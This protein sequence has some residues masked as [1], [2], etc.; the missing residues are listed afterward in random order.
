M[1]VDNFDFEVVSVTEEEEDCNCSVFKTL[2]YTLRITYKKTKI[3]LLVD[4]QRFKG[5]EPLSNAEIVKYIHKIA[6]DYLNGEW[7]LKTDYDGVKWY[8]TQKLSDHRD[9]SLNK[10]RCWGNLTRTLQT[11]MGEDFSNF[12]QS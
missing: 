2:Y 7:R 1:F 4:Y 6:Y 9:V 5:G 8:E 3:P 12:V 11:I 10:Y